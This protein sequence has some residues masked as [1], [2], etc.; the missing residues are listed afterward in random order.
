MKMTDLNDVKALQSNLH[1]TFDG[2]QG[3]EVMR[4]LEDIVGYDASV[5]DPLSK[6]NTWI[7]DGKR[8]VVATIKTLLKHKAED[9][10]SLAK[11]KEA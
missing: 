2:P 5:F 6:E 7:Q 11:Q 8:Q 9:I 3:Q 4:W 1:A 10:V